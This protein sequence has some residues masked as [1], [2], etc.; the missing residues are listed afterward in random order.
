[1]PKISKATVETTH[2]DG[3]GDP[4]GPYSSHAFSDSGGLTQFGVFEEILPPGSRSSLKHWHDSEDEM[5]YML[6]GVA[7]VT[8]GDAG[9]DLHPGEAA[10]F[11][12][13]VPAGHCLENRTDSPIRYLVIG[14]RSNSG[15]ATYPDHDR[16]LSF[17]RAPGSRKFTDRVF[18][19][20]DG[21]PADTPYKLEE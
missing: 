21:S 13:G 4:C 12:A 19:T 15:S 3:A 7:Y 11:K 17:T 1:M 6:D 14:T 18:T 8:E 5:V 9:Y 2:Q 20:L 10:T 16:H